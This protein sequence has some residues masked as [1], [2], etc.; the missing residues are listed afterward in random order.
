MGCLLEFIGDLVVDGY[1]ALM[2]MIL[3]QKRISEKARFVWELVIEVFAVLLLL[4]ILF[5]IVLL[6][7]DEPVARHVGRYMIFVPLGISA[8]QIAA[9]ILVR[10]L[11]HKRK[12]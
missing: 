11:V 12:K 9:G 4:S 8:V 5:G 2:C 6:F 3:P 7:N 1:A 10:L